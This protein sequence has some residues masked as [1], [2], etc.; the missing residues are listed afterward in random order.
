MKHPSTFGWLQVIRLGLIQACMGAVV[1]VTT[2][3]LNRIMV[4]ELALPALLPG[5]LVGFH[6]IVQMV[7]PR[8]GFGADAGGRCTPWMMGGMLVLATGGVLA[9]AGTIL[10][11]S[12]LLGGVLLSMLAFTLIGFG[13]S[14][15]GTSLLVLLAKRLPDEVRAPSATLVWMM[16]IFGFAATAVSVGKLLD[17]YS[18]ERL[19]AVTSGLSVLVVVITAACL[20]GLEGQAGSIHGKAEQR[21]S[22]GQFKETLQQVWHEP[23]ARAF[24]VFVFFSMLAYSFQDLIL[25]PFA[26]AVFEMTPGQTTQLSG[27]QHSS[28]LVGMIT[29]AV[30]GSAKVRGRLGS[31]QAW[32]IGGCLASAVAMAGLCLAGLQGPGWPL[33]FNVFALGVANGAFSI[34]AIATMMRLANEGAHGREGTRMGLWGAAQAIAFGLGGV[35]GT[36]A[37]DLAHWLIAQ[38]GV[39]YAT[40]FGLEALMFAVSAWCAVRVAKLAPQRSKPPHSSH[41]T[42]QESYQ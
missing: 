13:V 21:P 34:A 37:S 3:T 1:V 19:M 2:S 39:A 24:T 5:M 29:V 32:M 25:E 36:A 14:A 8:M 40:V 41:A 11:G 30:A 27:L 15:C 10:M 17:P 6:Y 33:K 9:C 16:M 38:S 22:A 35:L 26:G 42:L 12:F 4:V 28:V 20:W 31:V 18:P 23:Q 7:R